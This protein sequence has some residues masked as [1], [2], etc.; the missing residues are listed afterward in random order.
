MSAP[1]GFSLPP[2]RPQYDARDENQ[3]RDKIRIELERCV[4]ADQTIYPKR[5]VLRDASTGTL[6]ELSVTAGVLGIAAVTM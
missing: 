3:T 6:Y 2:A 1:V 5:F 4:K